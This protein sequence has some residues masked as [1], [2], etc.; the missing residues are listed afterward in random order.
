VINEV[1]CAAEATTM[2]RTLSKN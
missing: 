1:D 2:M